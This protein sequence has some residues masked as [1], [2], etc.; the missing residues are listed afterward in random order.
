MGEP[1]TKP[2]LYGG[3]SLGL[4]REYSVEYSIGSASANSG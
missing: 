4:N 1:D 2:I 3:G